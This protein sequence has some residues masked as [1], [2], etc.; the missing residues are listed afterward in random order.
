MPIGASPPSLFR[1]SLALD[2]PAIISLIFL[3]S[4]RTCVTKNPGVFEQKLRLFPE[5]RESEIG[6][7][8]LRKHLLAFNF[9]NA[10]LD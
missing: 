7:F 8:R 10:N 1:Q 4:V 3:Y 5:N 2:S 9:A 6:L